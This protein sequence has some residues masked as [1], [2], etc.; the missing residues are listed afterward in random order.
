MKDLIYTVSIKGLANRVIFIGYRDGQVVPQYPQP[1][2][3]EKQ[4]ITLLEIMECACQ[5]FQTHLF[6]TDGE[7]AKKYLQ[8]RICKR[9]I[10]L[11]SNHRDVKGG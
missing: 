5:F 2:L 6:G 3:S 10:P 11:Y 9:K 7:E 4:H 1:L 8:Q